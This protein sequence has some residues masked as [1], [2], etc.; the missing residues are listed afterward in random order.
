M[1]S[2]SLFSNFIAK[3]RSVTLMRKVSEEDLKELD[4]KIMPGFK[5][6]WFYTGIDKIEKEALF[7]EADEGSE[8]NILFIRI[9]NF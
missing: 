2:N 4:M 9:C 7:L 5:L 8:F 1:S 3:Y 6:T